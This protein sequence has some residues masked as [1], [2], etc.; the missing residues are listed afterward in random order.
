LH[1]FYKLF[2]VHSYIDVFVA[3]HNGHTAGIF[4]ENPDSADQSGSLPG[5]NSI[6]KDRNANIRV[7]TTGAS[8][9]LSSVSLSPSSHKNHHHTTTVPS[10]DTNAARQAANKKAKNSLRG[11]NKQRLMK[12]V[13]ENLKNIRLNRQLKE[14]GMP[15]KFAYFVCPFPLFFSCCCL[16]FVC[17]S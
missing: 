9:M 1:A 2:H 12:S 13:Q 11:K 14:D 15:C 5:N 8:D 17:Y 16:V 3:D 6:Q 7:S 10:R 4:Q